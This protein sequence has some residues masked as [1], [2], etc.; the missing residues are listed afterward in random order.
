MGYHISHLL[1]NCSGEFPLFMK[2]FCMFEIILKSETK[3]VCQ[4]KGNSTPL[5]G[6]SLLAGLSSC[7]RQFSVPVGGLVR[8]GDREMGRGTAH[9]RMITVPSRMSLL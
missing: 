4:I 6:V 1:S 7:G 5:P 2:R 3:E 9:V 8:A